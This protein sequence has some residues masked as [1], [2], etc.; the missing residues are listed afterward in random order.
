MFDDEVDGIPFLGGKC[1]DV[2]DDVVI[3]GFLRGI[4]EDGCQTTDFEIDLLDAVDEHHGLS[5]IVCHCRHF[6]DLV[7][8][9]FIILL[10]VN[11][12][13]DIFPP[14]P[15]RDIESAGE[16]VINQFDLDE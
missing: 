10:G 4:A 13:I 6:V 7:H 3:I 1:E 9:N 11:I 5:F 12:F 16:E 14:I 15:S 2:L 8:S